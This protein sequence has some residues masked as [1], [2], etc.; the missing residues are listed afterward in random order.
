MKTTEIHAD[1]IKVETIEA[2]IVENIKERKKV[3]AYPEDEVKT[4][5]KPLDGQYSCTDE[6]MGSLYYLDSHSE[7]LNDNHVVKSNIPVIGSILVAGRKLLYGEVR[8]CTDPLFL[9]ETEFNRH[10][11]NVLNDVNKKLEGAEKTAFPNKDIEAEIKNYMDLKF[12]QIKQELLLQI[13]EEIKNLYSD[14]KNVSENP[15]VLK[16]EN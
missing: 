16:P 6:K 3:G 2:Q 7:L 11:A 9:K 12:D 15:N 8:R 13:K 10:V 4:L 1:E 5:L 14:S